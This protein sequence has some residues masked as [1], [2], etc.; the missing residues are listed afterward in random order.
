MDRLHPE[1][2]VVYGIPKIN[3]KNFIKQMFETYMLYYEVLYK[4][5]N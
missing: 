2:D 5:N 1:K 3:K 4:L